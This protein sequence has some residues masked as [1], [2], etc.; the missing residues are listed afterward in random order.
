M[1]AYSAYRAFALKQLVYLGEKNGP[2]RNC[3]G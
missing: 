1:V 3:H 2:V